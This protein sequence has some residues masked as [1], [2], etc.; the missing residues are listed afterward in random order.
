VRDRSLREEVDH[1]WA[2]TRNPP[3]RPPLLPPAER[4]AQQHL[5]LMQ[6]EHPEEDEG[7]DS[8]E[9]ER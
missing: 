7:I 6:K 9:L 2:R 5:L 3:R 8:A 1:S 4:M